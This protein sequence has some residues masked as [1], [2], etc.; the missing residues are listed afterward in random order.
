M[1]KSNK[2]KA[3]I[4][5]LQDELKAAERNERAARK[6]TISRAAEKAGLLDFELSSAVLDAEFRRLAQR[7]APSNGSKTLGDVA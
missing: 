2:I 7:L 4:K 3:R 5:A 1:Q 6:S